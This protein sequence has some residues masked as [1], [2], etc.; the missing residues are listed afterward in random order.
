MHDG[1]VQRKIT[2]GMSN[3]VSQGKVREDH[4][5]EDNGSK[6]TYGIVW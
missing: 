6:L 3:K 1:R 4:V 2:Q 5:K